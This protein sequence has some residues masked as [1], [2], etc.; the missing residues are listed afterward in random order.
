[1]RR[2]AP[3]A[4]TEVAAVIDTHSLAPGL[5]NSSRQVTWLAPSKLP[6]GLGCT[7]P[8]SI[9][10]GRVSV[11]KTPL[12]SEEELLLTQIKYTK[13]FVANTSPPGR[14]LRTANPPM[15]PKSRVSSLGDPEVRVVLSTSGVVGT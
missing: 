14:D 12:S 6:P 8:G 4:L 3:A 9:P 5:S 13:G 15:K 2:Y 1:L 11:T 10:A 7:V